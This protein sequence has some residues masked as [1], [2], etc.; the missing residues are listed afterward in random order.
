M[1]RRKGIMLDSTRDVRRIMLIGRLLQNGNES[2][3]WCLGIGSE[4]HIHSNRN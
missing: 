2:F 3:D 4:I 1:G